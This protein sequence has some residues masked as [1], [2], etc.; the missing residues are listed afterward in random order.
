MIWRNPQ[1]FRGTCVVL[2]VTNKTLI[3]STYLC[4]EGTKKKMDCF[5]N[6]PVMKSSAR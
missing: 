4:M 1:Y 2:Y 6:E 5:K 3:I